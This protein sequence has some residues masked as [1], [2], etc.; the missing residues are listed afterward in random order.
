MKNFQ[1]KQRYIDTQVRYWQENKNA[2]EKVEFKETHEKK[3][4]PFITISREYGAGAFELAEK[5]TD[6]INKKYKSTPEWCAFDKE[7]LDKIGSDLGLSE[8]LAK[9]L[10]ESARKKM[11]DFI[12]TSFSS[13]PPQVHIYNKLV[14]NI[15]TLA[16]NG[17]AVIVGRT[18][19]IITRDMIKGFH[20]RLVAPLSYRVNRMSTVYN[21]AN[22]EAEKIIKEKENQRNSFIKEFVK[23]DNADPLNYHL[24][25]NLGLMSIDEAA[26]IIVNSMED[27]GYL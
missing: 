22:K 1:I 3:D 24:I 11:T 13:F 10:T 14:E 25:I 20:V 16:I 19:N 15:R 9:V 26:L 27:C 4:K 17:N 2:I 21:L 5:I 8:S 18:G 6:I 12:Q 23:F 7:L